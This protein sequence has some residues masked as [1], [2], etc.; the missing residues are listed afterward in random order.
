MRQQHSER[1]NIFNIRKLAH[2]G[3][4]KYLLY[5]HRCHDAQMQLL[6]DTP[7]AVV[8]FAAFNE[9]LKAKLNKWHRQGLKKSSKLVRTYL[10]Y[11]PQGKN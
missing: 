6:L 1:S 3:K 5:M 4:G 8:W 2:T 10:T 9:L 11:E 7:R